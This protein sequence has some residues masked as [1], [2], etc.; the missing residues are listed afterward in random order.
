VFVPVIL[1]TIT[2][3]IY[4]DTFHGMADILRPR[5]YHLLIGETGYSTHEEERIVQAFLG[6]R[7]AAIVLAGC[8]HTDRTR[9]LLRRAKIPV[10]EIWTL[11]P[12]PL[13]AAVGFSNF[14]AAR[15]MTRLLVARGHREIGFI[16]G[17]VE[18]NDRTQ[19]RERGYEDALRESGLVFDRSRMRR[20]PFEFRAGKEALGELLDAHPE[21]DAVFVAA[22]ILAVGAIEECRRRGLD[23]PEDLAIAGFDDAEIGS[24]IDPPL[25][26][27]RVPRYALGRVVAEHLLARFERKPATP[28]VI[29]LG[30]EIVSRAS[31]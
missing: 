8:V 10:V 3:S 7:P 9:G 24:V 17:L 2:N 6:W 4:A 27:V 1:P 13:D 22:D 16:G 14:E 15:Q 29:D 28:R 18:G 21:L 26:T 11:P 23:V 31:A 20:R 12:K 5:G 30:F 19:A 25:T